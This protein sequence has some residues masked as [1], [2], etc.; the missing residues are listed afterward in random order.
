MGSLGSLMGRQAYVGRPLQHNAPFESPRPL[1]PL[2]GAVRTACQ[3]QQQR[4]PPR[5]MQQKTSCN[6]VLLLLAWRGQCALSAHLMGLFILRKRPPALEG[7]SPPTHAKTKTKRKQSQGK[8]SLRFALGLSFLPTPT[9][10][11]ALVARHAEV[12]RQEFQEGGK[13]K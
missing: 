11:R 10:L 5:C 1:P 7:P 3:L 9:R 8:A 6:C 4:S 2:A 12:K 13:K